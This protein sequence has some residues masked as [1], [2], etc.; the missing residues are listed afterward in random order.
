MYLI[1]QK[2][3]AGFT[4]RNNSLDGKLAFLSYYNN[5]NV[6]VGENRIE[7]WRDKSIPLE[8][9]SNIPQ[10]G[11][12]MGESVQRSISFGS[13]GDVYIRIYSPQGFEIEISLENFMDLATYATIDKKFIIA[14][15]VFSWN[16]KGKLYLLPTSS[17]EYVASV[18]YSNSY[19]NA[20]NEITSFDNLKFGDTII[21]QNTTNVQTEP[22]IYVGKYTYFESAHNLKSLSSQTRLKYSI[23]KKRFEFVP[24]KILTS[25]DVFIK[26][27]LYQ[28][29]GT[30]GPKMINLNEIKTVKLEK[31]KPYI[32]VNPKNYNLKTW[33]NKNLSTISLEDYLI[34]QDYEDNVNLKKQLST[35]FENDK[36]TKDG[37]EIVVTNTFELLKNNL[38]MEPTTDEILNSIQ[39]S[40]YNN[41]YYYLFSDGNFY[42]TSGFNKQFPVSLEEYNPSREN[43][44]TVKQISLQELF[45]NNIYPQA[46]TVKDKSGKLHLINYL[47]WSYHK[48]RDNGIKHCK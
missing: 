8:N 9:F 1:P 3:T 44:N 40:T 25:E 37:F 24:G 32:S 35:M 13:G 6:F 5:K 31:D 30:S 43:F 10:S 12:V 21:R 26:S 11:F 2:L 19:F 27:Y 38:N 39:F 4:K 36:I 41:I 34:N 46:V 33:I 16:E 18:E 47:F 15:C 29:T 17:P 20:S 45:D 23:S 7:K 22:L 28:S 48:L 14:E 42:E